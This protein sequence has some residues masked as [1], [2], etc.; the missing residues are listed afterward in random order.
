MVTNV[1]Q[2]YKAVQTAGYYQRNDSID[3]Y[4]TYSC[5]SCLNPS[6]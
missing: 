6:Q 3:Q 1:Q 2:V 4:L 5:I